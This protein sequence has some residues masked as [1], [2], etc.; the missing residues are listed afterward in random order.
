[1]LIRDCGP[2]IWNED[3]KVPLTMFCSEI[4]ILEPDYKRYHL[5]LLSIHALISQ[6]CKIQQA[7]LGF[8]YT[9]SHGGG[10]IKFLTAESDEDKD[11]KS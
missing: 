3:E 5:C 2:T 8:F 9:Y 7:P 10:G 1:M 11:P 4:R 6:V